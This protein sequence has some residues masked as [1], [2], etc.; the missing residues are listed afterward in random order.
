MVTQDQTADGGAPA[1]V[2]PVR[3]SMVYPE[4]LSRLSTV[5]RIIL[6]IPVLIFVALIGGGSNFT[7][8]GDQA[9][10]NAR[11]ISIGGAGALLLAIWATIIVR[12]RIP[13]WLFNFQVA[14]HRFTYRAYAYL[15]L[16]TDKYPPFEGE[17]DLRYDVDYPEG[18]SRWRVFFWK[19]ITSIPH[20]IVLF[21][22]FIASFFVIF[23]GWW[24]ILFTGAFP[25]GLHSFVVGVLRWGARVTAYFESL[26]DVFP[27]YSL[28]EDAGPGSNSA[29]TISALI[30]GLILVGAV[31]GAITLAAVLYALFNDSKS[32]AVPYDDALAGELGTAASIEL[33]DVTFTLAGGSDDA[34]PGIIAPR[35]GMRLVEFAVE[36]DGEGDRSIGDGDVDI[37]QDTI[38][39]ET[40]DEGVIDPVLLT[41]DGQ[42]A[43]LEVPDGASGTL[44]AF[45]EVEDRDD[46]LELRAYPNSNND[47]HVAWEFE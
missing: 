35:S 32:V 47:R 10:D 15:G 17:G 39:L 43:P 30:G 26:T 14:V 7:G 1:R 44:R 25:R 41:F 9:G 3:L 5:F 2:Y 36:Y 38:R 29:Q 11:N 31:A 45:F 8:F 40:D 21:F 28:E 42:V 24:A 46:V 4:R 12:Q 18:L 19:L 37:D 20:F 22:L 6:A 23:I 33:D 34:D 13:T 16:L 27:P